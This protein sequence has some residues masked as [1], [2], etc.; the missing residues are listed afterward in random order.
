MGP[1]SKEAMCKAIGHLI[2]EA[3]LQRELVT[4]ELGDIK[5][6]LQ[7]RG[8]EESD[9]QIRIE[10][11]VVVIERRLGIHAPVPAE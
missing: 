10:R 6:L 2:D 11:R 8:E 3:Q 7:V 4:K 1:V 5:H 9:A